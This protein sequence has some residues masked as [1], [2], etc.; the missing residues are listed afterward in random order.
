M[1]LFLRAGA[2]REMP[3]VDDEQCGAESVALLLRPLTI[4]ELLD[5]TFSLY[6]D[7]FRLFSGMMIL[8]QLAIFAVSTS[9]TILIGMAGSAGNSAAAGVIAVV[10]VLLYIPVIWGIQV[11]ATS[12]ALA[13]TSYGVSQVYLE[14]GTTISAAY[15]FVRS[16]FWAV[17]FVGLL[18]WVAMCV[19]ILAL[20]IGMLFALLFFSMA[21]PATVLEGRG[22][23]ESM[24]RSF[25]LVKDDLGRVFLIFFVFGVYQM[26]VSWVI[27]FPSIALMSALSSHGQG[28]MW[29]NSLLYLGN[30]VSGCLITP[31]L[32]IAIALAYYDERIRKEAFDMQFMMAAIDRNAMAS[33]AAVTGSAS[34]SPA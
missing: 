18:T 6:R 30:F 25:N 27:A 22:V 23:L 16:R 26:G 9:W 31:L 2:W 33:K 24:K 17:L 11:M 14:R 13:A 34:V 10:G 19:G 21:V 15:A 3:P 1:Q 29:V 7:H 28:P 4:G 20:F 32:N 8:P 12:M 5:Q